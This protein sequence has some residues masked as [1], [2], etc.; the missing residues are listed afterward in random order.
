MPRE[1]P[2]TRAMREAR[3]FVMNDSGST[4]TFVIRGVDP[5]IIN[6]RVNFSN[7]MDCRVKPGNDERSARFRKQGQLP[8]LGLDLGLVGEMRRIGAGKA[9]IGEFRTGGVAAGLAHRAVHAVDRQK[10]QRV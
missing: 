1:A 5:G 4:Y 3:G 2:V 8:R 7:K 6:L 9:V 10:R